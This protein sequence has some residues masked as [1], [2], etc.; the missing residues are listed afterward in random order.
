M[1]FQTLLASRLGNLWQTVWTYG[2]YGIGTVTAWWGAWGY[3]MQ[4]YFDFLGYSMMAVGLAEVL[5]FTLPDNFDSPYAARTMTAFWRRWHITLGKWFRDYLYIP[6]GGSRKGKGRMILALFL[7]WTA[8]AIWHGIGWN[9]LIWGG[10]LFLILLIEKLTFGK[11]MEKSFFGHLYMFILI[12]VSW[13]IFRITDV[14]QLFHYLGRMFFLPIGK[15]TFASMPPALNA[16]S[17]LFKPSWWVMLTAVFFSTPYP[18]K[19]F[20]RFSQTWI[21]RILVLI[22][23]LLSLHQ[24]AMN[25]SNPFMYLD[26]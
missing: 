21:V 14:P 13:M 2:P 22:L 4:L 15:E 5:G 7:T 3:S 19:W 10:F 9:F 18:K 26:F 12:P 17:S 20:E 6:L 8:T 16:M 25:G 23:F 11:A 1:A 24:I